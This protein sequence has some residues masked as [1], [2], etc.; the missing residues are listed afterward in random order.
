MNALKFP[1]GCIMKIQLLA[2]ISTTK[3]T[4]DECIVIKD[5]QG[6]SEG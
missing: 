2:D 5:R 6:V 1:A 3:I 4:L